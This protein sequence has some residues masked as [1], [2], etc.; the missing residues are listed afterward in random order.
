LQMEAFLPRCYDGNNNS[1]DTDSESTVGAESCHPTTICDI[2]SSSGPRTSGTEETR[3]TTLNI[4]SFYGPPPWDPLPL[5]HAALIHY[6]D[7]GDV[8]TCV[9]ILLVLGERTSEEMVD[10]AIQKLW[11][12]D[13]LD[14]LDRYELWVTSAEII[15]LCWIPSV[16]ILSHQSWCTIVYAAPSAQIRAVIVW[17]KAFGA[18]VED[19]VTAVIRSIYLNGSLLINTAQLDADIAAQLLGKKRM[20]DRETMDALLQL[21]R[22]RLISSVNSEISSFCGAVR[23]LT[24]GADTSQKK[25]I[26][27]ELVRH[28]FIY[29][30]G[31]FSQFTDTITGV[32][33]VPEEETSRIQTATEVKTLEI[34]G[35]VSA[36]KARDFAE[37]M[38]YSQDNTIDESYMLDTS[39]SEFTCS[40]LD[41][42]LTRALKNAGVLLIRAI[43]E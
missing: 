33:P 30:D 21:L 16:S 23:L 39:C 10:V 32:Y 3:Q 24:D 40:T 5:I 31:F 9:S 29:W 12:L 38:A 2:S 11:F 1:E 15:K 36:N 43:D 34:A 6:A 35:G 8:Q 42:F 13:Y 7:N 14:V 4:D 25:I 20:S 17:W 22:V 19:V 28:M 26:F 27:V 37:N 18:G 41:S